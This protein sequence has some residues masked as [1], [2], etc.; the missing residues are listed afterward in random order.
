MKIVRPTITEPWRETIEQAARGPR[1]VEKLEQLHNRM[2]QY[3]VL[4]PAC[5]SGNF[6][7]L[8]YR[9]LK[10]LEVD[11]FERLATVSRSK[12]KTRR[13]SF[14]TAA[15]F[16]GIDINPFAVEIAKVTMMIARKLAIDELGITERALPLDNLDDNFT[17]ADALIHP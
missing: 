4:D 17:A 14:V 10:R 12:E 6:L 3:R 1:P 13:M 9:E 2:Q 7:Y 15:Q 8:A 16:F 11:L 5:G